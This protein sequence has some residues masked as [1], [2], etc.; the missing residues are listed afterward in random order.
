M[1]FLHVGDLHIGKQ[2]NQKSL[3]ADQEHMLNE[4]IEMMEEND[5]NTL[6]IA[7]DIYDK[8][9][10]SKEAVKLFNDFLV[11]AILEHKYKI[12]II[13]GNHDSIERLNFASSILKSEGLYIETYGGKSIAKYEIHDKFG[14][15]NLYMLPFTTPDYAKFKFDFEGKTYA[16]MIRYYVENTNID[17]K[18]RNILLTH[19]T[20]LHYNEALFS[21]S[22]LRFNIGGTEGIDATY[23]E[24]FDYVALGHL[25]NPQYLCKDYIRYSGSPLKYSESE[26]KYE[27]SCVMVELN[28]KG[29]VN[30]KTLPFK[31]LRD[32]INIKGSIEEL[33]ADP[34][35]TI[36]DYVY[37]TL[38]DTQII[39]YAMKR[40]K[41]KYPNAVSLTYE[42]VNTSFISQEV[43][44]SKEFHEK[45]HSEQFK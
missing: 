43:K 2:L 44:V 1:K 19:H 34:E 40:I 33:L 8:Q 11:N 4:I 12:Y 10:P 25:H 20:L 30:I 37:V 31:P 35:N 22:E 45:N 32:V 9:I 36:D 24:N 26:I 29:N 3:I 27:K 41:V 7:G 18:E 16:D 39:P 21:D 13:S 38:T 5:I 14:K 6:L 23:F 17:Y 28:E 15:V 42:H